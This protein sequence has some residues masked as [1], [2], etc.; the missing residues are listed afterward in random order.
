[1]SH[2][3]GVV[4]VAEM[5]ALEA[6]AIAAGTPEREL[7]E[8]AG[9]AVAE[10]V[11]DR[12]G[13]A[14]ERVA[15]LV[16]AGN[17]GRDGVVAGR[18][19]AERGHRVQLWLTPRH[20]LDATELADLAARGIELRSTEPSEQ[21]V[22]LREALAASR[23][24]I[25]GLLGVGAR[26]PMR[27][28]LAEPAEVLNAVRAGHPRLLV[29]AVDVPS[30]L[31]AD[32][33]SV[34]G[35]AVAADVTVTFG[36]VKAGLLRFPG[37]SLVGRLEPRPI[38][39]P[40]SATAALP[41][42][43][44]DEAAVRP[45]L[46]ARPL[47]AHKYRLGR[48]LVV[49]GSDMYVGAAT[50]CTAAAARSG[51]GLVAVAST[52]TV[53]AV[54][55]AR[56]PEA[57]YPVPPLELEQ[58]PEGSAGRVVDA[59]P[60][61]QSLVLGP[62][63]GRAETTDRFLRRLLAGNAGLAAPVP[64]VIDADA[65]TLLARWPGWWEQIGPSHVLTPH[66]GEM[67]RLTGDRSE[68]AP[69]ERA[70]EAAARWGQ[71]VVLKGPFTSVA[72]PDGPVWVY[73]HANPALASAGTGDVLAGLCAGLL[74]QGLA[75]ADAAC[76]AVVVHALAGRR[77]VDCRA[78]RTLLASDLLEEIPWALRAIERPPDG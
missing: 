21:G 29:V 39:L 77:V 75:P 22:A 16:G 14:G 35:S 52:T 38:G 62:G 24:A 7:Q 55:A 67:A 26:G 54:L 32:D 48:T 9:R 40:A 58:D 36:A 2:P 19:L 31:N 71:V 66:A 72:S 69:W 43:I 50:L 61:Y 51:C 11:S 42:R 56:L 64:T 3:F 20:A 63:I 5:R 44:L 10:V 12:L 23:V 41:T 59:L 25:D 46:P 65:L 68:S 70:R 34:P 53:K 4:S 1:V 78:W 57:T 17:N 73:P 13:S 74:A 15:V 60:D 45:L 49:A 33:G 27:P 37:A 6:A 18:H 28:G 8:R 47:D 76:L 30:G